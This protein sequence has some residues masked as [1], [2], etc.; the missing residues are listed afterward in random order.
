MGRGSGAVPFD[1]M[2]IDPFIW[3]DPTDLDTMFQLSDGTVPVT[4]DNDPVG[5]WINKVEDVNG[6]I[7]PGAGLRPLYNTAGGVH[8]VEADG[9]DD[10]LDDTA[11][12]HAQP[13]TVVSSWRILAYPGDFGFLWGSGANQDYGLT[14][15]PTLLQMTANGFGNFLSL[16]VPAIGADFTVVEIYNGASSELRIIGGD[17]DTGNA[18]AN[19]LVGTNLFAR[20]QDK[21]SNARLY[22]QIGVPGVASEASIAALAAYIAANNP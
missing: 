4:A 5:T 12:G 11:I 10:F 21:L 7:Q 9:S 6:S 18:G 14:I 20:A 8:W 17:T 22:G 2:S 3:Y 15:T 19:A 13:F 1:P 16:D